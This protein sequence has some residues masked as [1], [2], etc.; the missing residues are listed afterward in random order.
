MVRDDE[1]REDGEIGRG[2][3]TGRERMVKRGVVRGEG[4]LDGR[5]GERGVGGVV[6]GSW[7]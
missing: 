3:K 5:G 7:W 4:W 2:G 1:R 6:K